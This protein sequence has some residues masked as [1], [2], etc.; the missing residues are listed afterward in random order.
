[1]ANANISENLTRP[2]FIKDFISTNDRLLICGV[3]CGSQN[4]SANI[5][6]TRKADQKAFRRYSQNQPS[7]V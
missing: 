2:Q 3:P 7:L 6:R 1:M 4:T 5:Y